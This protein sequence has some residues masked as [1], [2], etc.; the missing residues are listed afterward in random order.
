MTLRRQ[1]FVACLL[2]AALVSLFISSLLPFHNG[3]GRTHSRTSFTLLAP[4]ATFDFVASSTS[5]SS[6]P[7]PAR[8]SARPENLI[9]LN[10]ARLC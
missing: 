8:N 3:T 5:L 10:C 1:N 7:G 2:V 9:E 4:L 6:A